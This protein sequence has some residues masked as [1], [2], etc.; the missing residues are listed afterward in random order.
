MQ[1][2]VLRED[3]NGINLSC[4]AREFFF[5]DVSSLLHKKLPRLIFICQVIEQVLHV[6]D[7]ICGNKTPIKKLGISQ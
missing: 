2:L 6:P 3:V 7:F 4:R 1:L 5:F